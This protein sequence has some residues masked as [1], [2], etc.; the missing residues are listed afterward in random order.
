MLVASDL[1]A[2][3]KTSPSPN[4][5]GI[6]SKGPNASCADLVSIEFSDV[7]P[8]ALFEITRVFEHTG[9]SAIVENVAPY[10]AASAAKSM[11]SRISADVSGCPTLTAS[12]R[13][14]SVTFKLAVA[15]T[16]S[17]GTLGSAVTITGTGIASGLVETNATIVQG[18]TLIGVSAPTWSEAN[19]L[20]TVALKKLEAQ[21]Q[22]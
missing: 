1:P 2:G 9:G 10:R 15:P 13:G 12:Y 18:S 7:V 11:I 4:P 3:Y 22:K 20:T 21:G 17:A 8:G 16:P 6:T 5:S 14:T 19:D